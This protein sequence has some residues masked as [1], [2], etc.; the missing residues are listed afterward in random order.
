M[1]RGGGGGGKGVDCADRLNFAPGHGL[2]YEKSARYFECAVC[3]IGR[4]PFVKIH[5]RNLD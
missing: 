4:P 3:K 1:A 5:A 2:N